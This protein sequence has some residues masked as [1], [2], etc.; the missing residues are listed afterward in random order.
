MA[1]LVAK[2]LPLKRNPAQKF[3]LL[4]M[5]DGQAGHPGQH[6]QQIACISVGEVAQT[7]PHQMEVAIAKE[8][9]SQA[10]TAQEACV[11]QN[12]HQ[13]T[14]QWLCMTRKPQPSQHKEELQHLTSPST[15][16]WPLLSLCLF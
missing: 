2:D 13:E 14:Y 3:V 9:I 8:K 1:D 5:E 15:L 10:K 7:Q 16:G 11:D 4:L 6:A 12:W